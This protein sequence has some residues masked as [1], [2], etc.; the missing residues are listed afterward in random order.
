[1]RRIR[2]AMVVTALALAACGGAELTEQ[3][4]EGQEG[5]GDVEISEDDGTVEIEIETDEGDVSAVFG[6]GDLP[7][8]FPIA[9]PDGGDVKSVVESGG[10]AS[11]SLA[12]GASEFDSI[13]SFY[14]NWVGSSGATVVSKSE[15]SS[16]RAVTWVLEM[17]S[18]FYNIIV[19]EAVDLTIVNLVVTGG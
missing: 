6:G 2:I 11:V 18:Q 7:A 1:M 15:M 16:P 5:V 10:E 4:I 9:V 13:K 14:E 12:F 8:G 19:S 3:I 17:G